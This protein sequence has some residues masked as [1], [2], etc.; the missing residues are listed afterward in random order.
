[1]KSP[2]F[3]PL[4]DPITEEQVALDLSWSADARTTQA[5][6]RQAKL[7]GFATPSDYLRQA[8]AAVIAGN[9]AMTAVIADWWVNGVCCNEPGAETKI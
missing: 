1:M 7:M 2:R 3:I 4:P 6:E 5:I 8:L 9:E